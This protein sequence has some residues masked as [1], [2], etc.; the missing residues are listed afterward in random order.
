MSAIV[1]MAVACQ[2]AK[3]SQAKKEEVK[4]TIKVVPSPQQ[5]RNRELLGIWRIEGDETENAAFVIKPDSI[6]YVEQGQTYLLKT[7]KDSLYIYYTGWT[8]KASYKVDKGILIMKD[9]NRENKFI[10]VK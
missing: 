9:E 6:F 3:S 8:Y 10:K 4:D 2:D 1:F 7:K 5:D